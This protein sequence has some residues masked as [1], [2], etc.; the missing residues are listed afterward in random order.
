MLTSRQGVASELP[1]STLTRLALISG[2]ARRSASRKNGPEKK[3]GANYSVNSLVAIPSVAG[4]WRKPACLGD[5]LIKIFVQ[6]E[7]AVDALG[8]TLGDQG[9]DFETVAF[10]VEE[11]A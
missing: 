8:V 1:A 2:L 11:I 10:G 4:G 6:V 3:S 5:D 7:R 9:V